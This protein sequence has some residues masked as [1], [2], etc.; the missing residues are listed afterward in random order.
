MRSQKSFPSD[1]QHSRLLRTF[2]SPSL[3]LPPPVPPLTR[4]LSLHVGDGTEPLE[5]AWWEGKALTG[6]SPDA[7]PCTAVILLGHGNFP[8]EE[9]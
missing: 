7:T 4:H 5:A 3:L 9:G 6:L 2:L 1:R 8:P